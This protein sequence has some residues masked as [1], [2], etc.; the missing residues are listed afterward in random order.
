MINK[1]EFS[2]DLKNSVQVVFSFLTIVD[3]FDEDYSFEPIDNL[4]DIETFLNSG[5]QFNK[6][7]LKGNYEQIDSREDL[8][9]PISVSNE[10]FFLVKK[11]NSFKN[12]SIAVLSYN[13]AIEYSDPMCGDYKYYYFKIEIARELWWDF[14]FAKHISN[15]HYSS[16]NI[17][18]FYVYYFR[19]SEQIRDDKKISILVTNTKTRR[20]GYLKILSN[21]LT[22]NKKTLINSIYKKFEKYCAKYASNLEYNQY[23]KGLISETKTGISAKPYIDISEGFGILN[24]ITTMFYPSKSFRVYQS[25]QMQ[26][27]QTTNIFQLSDFD[28]IFFLECILKT[29]YF[30]FKNLLEILYV[31]E[32]VSY[33]F[34]VNSFQSQILKSL[35]NLRQA[36]VYGD[37]NLLINIETIINRIEKWEKPLV[38]LEHILMPRL[39]WMLDFG[40][41]TEKSNE[42]EINKKGIKLFQHLCI[43]NDINTEEIISTDSFLDRFMIHLYDECFKDIQPISPLSYEQVKQ[44]LFKYIENSFELFKTLAPNRVT[45]SQAANYAKYKLYFDE[46]IKVGYQFILSELSKKEQDKFIFKYQEQYKDGYIQKIK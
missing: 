25:L 36:N 18:K 2:F 15:I 12:D 4:S 10:M 44:T 24:K 43:W 14:E 40:M 11:L 32:N 37:R 8:E 46:N 30:Y 7:T 20:L 5:V 13:T 34:L 26:Y 45:A 33:S 28:K 22:E 42:F 31:N 1:N 39:N 6:L 35:N 9:E 29:D 16:V 38:Y 27:S 3:E 23:K 21:F 41:L 19:K 17:P